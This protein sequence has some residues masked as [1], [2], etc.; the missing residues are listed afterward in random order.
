[1]YSNWGC[2]VN[3]SP[4]SNVKVKNGWSYTST[5]PIRLQGVNTET[6][7]F[8]LY[9]G[10]VFLEKLMVIHPVNKYTPLEKHSG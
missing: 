1:M 10:V 9:N 5:A 6:L 2:E 7:R 3:D 8:N 4:T